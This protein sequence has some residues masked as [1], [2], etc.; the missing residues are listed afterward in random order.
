M[1]E[2]LARELG[3]QVIQFNDADKAKDDTVVD[4][5][6]Q[7]I[8]ASINHDGNQEVKEGHEF[9]PICLTDS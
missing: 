3:L 8:P 9:S 2:E 4:H 5:E 1:A 7:F 6:V